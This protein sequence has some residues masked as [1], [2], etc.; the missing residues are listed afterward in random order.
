MRIA[1]LDEAQAGIKISRR[2][3]NNQL[4][5]PTHSKTQHQISPGTRIAVLALMG[6][7]EPLHAECLYLPRPS[8]VHHLSL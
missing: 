6:L 3:N 2:N 1:G 4:H 8:P 7:E 5:S